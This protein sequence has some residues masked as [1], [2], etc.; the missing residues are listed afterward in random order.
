MGCADDHETLAAVAEHLGCYPATVSKWRRVYLRNGIEGLAIASNPGAGRVPDD[1]VDA[2]VR[3]ALR[4]DPFGETCVST[5]DAAKIVGVSHTTVAEIWRSYGIT[6]WL[7]TGPNDDDGLPEA[8]GT[9]IGLHLDPPSIGVAYIE[10]GRS[11]SASARRMACLDAVGAREFLDDEWTTA[12]AGHFLD[13]LDRVR[14]DHPSGD[15]HVIIT[16]TAAHTTRLVQK[17]LL[18]NPQI[19]VHF[20]P[21]ANWRKIVHGALASLSGREETVNESPELTDAI[22]GWARGFG[23]E[24]SVFTWY[25]AES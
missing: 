22:R 4:A 18:A 15:V 16:D 10:N 17:W 13:F 12:T 7:R 5:R 19:R 11:G 3:E 25:P 6:P 1:V 23:A 8:N 2:V 9:L 20:V 21:A 24:H 14:R